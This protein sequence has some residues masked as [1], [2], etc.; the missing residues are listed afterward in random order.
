MTR[1]IMTHGSIFSYTTC[2]GSRIFQWL[3]ILDEE[4]RC[5]IFL[6]RW[7]FIDF[8]LY[9]CHV[10]KIKDIIKFGSWK[11]RDQAR[12]EYVTLVQTD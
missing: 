8:L 12:K 2:K 5:Q 11:I 3:V 1:S 4:S 10:Q 9:Y 7:I 6:H